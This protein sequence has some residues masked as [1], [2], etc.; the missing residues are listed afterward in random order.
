[1]PPH[2][3]PSNESFD[4]THARLNDGLKCCRAVLSNYRTLLAGDG[5]DDRCQARFGETSEL[6]EWGDN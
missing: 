1:V 6:R 2:N 3:D 5:D 4:A